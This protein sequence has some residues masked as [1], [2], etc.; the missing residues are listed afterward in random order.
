[1]P[2]RVSRSRI[3][4][5]AAAALALT[6]AVGGAYASSDDSDEV[7]T[8]CYR[9]KTGNLR[10]E[11]NAA[12]CSTGASKWAKRERRISWNQE[13]IPGAQGLP[14]VDGKDGADGADGADGENGARGAVGPMGPAGPAGLQGI[15]GLPGIPGLDG[16]AGAKGEKGEQGEAGPQGPMGP[17]G[18]TGLPGAAGE[19]GA[20]G[21]TGPVGP[22]GPKG[23]TGA[24][25]APGPK[26]DTGEQGPR[27]EVGP[28]GP[29]GTGGYKVLDANGG[30][31]GT[32]VSIADAGLT[33]MTSSNYLLNVG[34]DGSLYPAQAYYTGAGCTGT[35]YLNSGWSEAGPIYAKTLVYLGTPNTLAVPDTAVGAMSAPNVALTAATIDNPECGASAG[36]R[37]G[38]QLKHVSAAAVGL[39]ALSGAGQFAVP[40]SIS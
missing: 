15:P 35:A 19:D 36:T 22:P 4:G 28:Q 37:H 32:A 17:M 23:D 7:I 6:A 26:G 34:W 16:A 20:P 30:L 24:T 29:A 33:V 40:L 13:G 2:S 10:L 9:L 38:Y 12:P 3:A 25:G 27:G 14:G 5:V 31:I 11:T 1:M 39:P 21:A 8:A 18:A